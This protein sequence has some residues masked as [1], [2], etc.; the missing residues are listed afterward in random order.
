M[1]H[2]RSI[3]LNEVS[4]AER[5]AERSRSTGGISSVIWL[6]TYRCNLNCIHCYEQGTSSEELTTEDCLKII[7]KLERAGKPL[8]FISGGEPLLREDLIKLLE[9]LKGRGFRVILSTNGTLISDELAERLSGLVSN[10]SLPLY[11]PEEFHDAFTRARGSYCKVIR[12]L[13]LLRSSVGLTLKSVV[14]RSTSRHL[15][16]LIELALK[17]GVGSI[18]LCDLLPRPGMEGEVLG[19]NEWRKLVEE[20]I[21]IS[22]DTGIEMDIGLHPSAAIYA[23]MRLGYSASEIGEKLRSKRLA[24]EGMGFISLAPNGDVLVSNYAPDLRIGNLLEESPD[25]L[26]KKE[27]Y[28]RLGDSGS[29]KGK[30]SSCPLLDVC[31]GS[32]AKAHFYTGDVLGEDPT[33]L[34]R[35][36]LA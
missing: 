10:V 6:L 25:D 36:V 16:H 28:L 4:E 34:V 2:L 13:A 14:T 30:C 9:E 20:L 27:L 22:L 29:I 35:D 24:K 5:V 3:I 1:V 7:D 18:Y 15:D 31:G 32:R 21:R 26:L 12:S 17:F 23:L 33:C 11:G 8:L 19:R